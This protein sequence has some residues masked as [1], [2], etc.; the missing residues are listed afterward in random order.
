[1][2]VSFSFGDRADVAGAELFRLL[3]LL[4]LEREQRADAL[5]AC[6]REFTS[7]ESE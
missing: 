5:L 6:V 2:V 4:A 3:V 7:V 1:M